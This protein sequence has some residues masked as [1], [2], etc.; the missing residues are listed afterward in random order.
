MYPSDLYLDILDLIIFPFYLAII[1]FLAYNT[2]QKHIDENPAYK[3]FVPGL[4][5]K[6][7]C[8]IAFVLIYVYYYKGGDGL[9]YFRGARA[10]SK[11][12][13]KTP[14]GCFSLLAGNN[15]VDNWHLFDTSTG[16]PVHEMFAL[17]PDSWAVS[18]LSAPILFISFNSFLAGVAVLDFLIYKFMWRFYLMFCEI[19]PNMEK[20]LAIGILFFP[21][22]G[23]WGSAFMKDT[24]TL[25]SALYFTYNFYMIFIKKEKLLPNIIAIIINAVIMMTLKPYVLVALLPATLLWG[26]Y[27]RVNSIQNETLRIF[28]TPF[29]LL[30]GI[31]LSSLVF[32]VLGSS[33]GAYGSVESMLKKAQVTQQDLVREEQYGEHKFD[34]GKFEPTLGG[35]LGKAPVAIT[36]GLFR[37]FI[38]EAG[39][40][41]M[42][43]SGLE[44]LVLLLFTVFIFFKVGPFKTFK[45]IS[46]EPLLLFSVTFSIVMAFSV[47]LTSANFGALTRYKIPLIPF[48]VATLFILHQKTKRDTK[49]F[50]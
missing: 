34:I 27:S 22:V 39:N 21:S 12:F 8:G 37:P 43:I 33:L 9:N 32:S 45:Y 40:V 47:G 2:K 26:S 36:A 18:R 29:L 24:F 16:F 35:V 50:L 11:V 28:A 15:S 38:W 10:I 25:A 23:F 4:F 20:Q 31:G 13:F 44:N 19:Y 48:Y 49:V 42:L 17:K 6:I 30:I 1:L 46:T 7:F 41:V 14:I 5:F 3:Y